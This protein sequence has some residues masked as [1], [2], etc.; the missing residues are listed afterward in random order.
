MQKTIILFKTLIYT[1]LFLKKKVDHITLL[2]INIYTWD[3]WMD[4]EVPMDK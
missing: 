2:R 4:F 1:I 3:G